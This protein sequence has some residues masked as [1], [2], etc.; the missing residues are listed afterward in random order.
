MFFF[1][2]RHI[3]ASFIFKIATIF[4]TNLLKY[5]HTKETSYLKYTTIYRALLYIV[6]KFKNY[7]DSLFCVLLIICDMTFL[8]Y[9]LNII[10]YYI[11][12]AT[13]DTQCYNF[14]SN[15]FRKEIAYE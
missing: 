15:I 10:V 6:Q 9:L 1:K 11:S 14:V 7:L 2:N 12:I 3:F 13:A 5:I 4:Q 8:L